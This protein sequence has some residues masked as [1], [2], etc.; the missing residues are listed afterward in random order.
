LQVD[1]ESDNIMKP[2]KKKPG[3]ITTNRYGI[4]QIYPRSYIGRLQSV[5]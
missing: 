3:P 5:K 2:G 4:S 1:V